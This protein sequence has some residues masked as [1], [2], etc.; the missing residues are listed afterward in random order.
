MFVSLVEFMF[1]I[2]AT[3]FFCYLHKMFLTVATAAAAVDTN[4]NV[5][6][7][8]GM[9][10]YVFYPMLQIVCYKRIS[11]SSGKSQMFTLAQNLSVFL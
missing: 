8:V 9:H 3:V 6:A 5:I 1:G 2:Q 7:V 10:T 11:L 4:I